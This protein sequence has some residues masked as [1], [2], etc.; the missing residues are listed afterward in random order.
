MDKKRLDELIEE[1]TV[2]CYDED[3]AFWGFLA[4][5]EDALNCPFEASIIGERVKVRGVDSKKSYPRSG[6][7]ASVERNGRSY[8]ISLDSLKDIQAD[9]ETV[10]WLAA[11]RRWA[12]LG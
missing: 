10:E 9:A 12:G 2:D 11:Y 3:E 1:A 4:M 7:M 5:L 8:T 6:I